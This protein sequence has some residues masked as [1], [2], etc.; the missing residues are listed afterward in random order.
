[1][2][3][4]RLTAEE[5]DERVASANRARTRADLDAVRVD[6]PLSIAVR[7]QAL[8]EGDAPESAPA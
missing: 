1:M 5:F 8:S 6:L 3:A 4:G 2:L 7:Q